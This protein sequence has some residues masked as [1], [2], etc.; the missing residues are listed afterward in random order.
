MVLLIRNFQN[1]QSVEKRHELVVI[2]Y[3]EKWEWEI[4]TDA[5][6]AINRAM[7]SWFF[8]FAG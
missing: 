1:S 2:G 5:Y 7:K 6:G 4:I 3:Y 8:F